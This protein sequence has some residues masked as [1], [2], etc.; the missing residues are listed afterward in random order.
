[1]LMADESKDEGVGATMR[2]INRA[3]MDSQVNDLAPMVHPEIVMVFP[4]F[5][6]RIQGRDAFLG[7]FRD[8]CENAKTH[9]FE[10]QD[11]QIDVAGDT[12][13]VSFRFE[14]LYERAGQR[15]RSSGR[16]LWVFQRD[17]EDWIAVWRTML[18]AEE[19]EAH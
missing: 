18:D 1:M 3:W 10:E 17:G 6:G 12:A 15:Y 16:D 13:V 4:G 19:Q 11:Q 7:G 14:M 8:F 2:R 9:E 5:A